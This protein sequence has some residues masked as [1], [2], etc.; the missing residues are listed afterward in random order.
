[1]MFICIAGITTILLRHPAVIPTV[2]HPRLVTP[3]R[4]FLHLSITQP[5]RTPQATSISIQSRRQ[6]P[7]KAA[8]VPFPIT[9]KNSNLFPTRQ[10]PRPA[11]QNSNPRRIIDSISMTSKSTAFAIRFN[12]E[13]TCQNWKTFCK[14]M[15]PKNPKCRLVRLQKP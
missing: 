14:S 15:K 3:C 13:V 9:K 8:A 1:M 6:L 4:N 7:S 11:R 2:N 5:R 12:S 10:Y